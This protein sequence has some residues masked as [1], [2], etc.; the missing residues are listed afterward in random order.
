[1]SRFDFETGDLRGWLALAEQMNIV[2]QVPGAHWNL[3]I[4]SITELNNYQSHPKAL[5]FEDIPD[6]PNGRVL[7]SAT[8]DVKTLGLTLG[9]PEV[10]D[11]R[12][13]VDKLRGGRV[14]Q[15][16]TDAEKYG[17]EWVDEGPVMEN[18]DTGSDVD[19]YRFPTPFWH[20]DDG[21][22]YIG[23]GSAVITQD[24]ETGQYNAGAYRTMLVDEKK[25]T[26]HMASP[27]RHGY[28]HMEKFHKQGKPCPVVVS[29][30][31]N[32]LFTVLSGLEVPEGIFELDVAGAIAEKPVRMVRG[33]ITG[34]PIPVDAE[35]VVEGWLTGEQADEGPFGEF[36]GYYAGGRRPSPV[37]Q[38]EAVYYRNQPILLG[39]PPGRPPHDFS[40]YFS[41]LRSALI[42]D[43]LELAGV[44]GVKAVWADEVGG[45]RQLITV[46]IKQRYMGHSRQAA[47]V[48]SQCQAGAYF[49]RYVVV[50]DDDIDPTNLQEVMWAVVTRSDPGSD[51][52]IMR[53]T[54]GSPIDPLACTYPPGT[55]YNTRAIIDACRPFEHLDKFPKVAASS[56][57]ELRQTQSKWSH[58]WE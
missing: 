8:S 45:A 17:F 37:I 51:I 46:A 58:I 25:M 9:Y 10:D 34:L 23:T 32:P 15:W 28:Q 18:V 5:L 52:E 22:R 6:Y 50:V 39:S 47:Y 24:P 42:G 33:Q 3:E 2:R 1:M 36:T 55:R 53:R 38:V 21:G 44:P 27:S 57:E 13:L 41:V 19:L 7:T 30:G 12:T 40:Y 16:F 11:P 31:H 56:P 49:G 14:T 43:Q 26:V 54:T 20:S 4:G 35:L 48:A 29:L